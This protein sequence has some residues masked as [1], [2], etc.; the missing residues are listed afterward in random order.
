VIYGIRILQLLRAAEI[1]AHL[2]MSRSTQVTLRIAMPA[3]VA[4]FISGTSS[5]R[6]GRSTAIRL[7][8][9]ALPGSGLQSS[10][11]VIYPRPQGDRPTDG[12]QPQ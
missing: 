2:V 10:V 9:S 3:S 1:E 4:T 8:T 12:R 6:C 5:W 11:M 7:A